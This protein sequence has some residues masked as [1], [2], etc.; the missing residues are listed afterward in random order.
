[1]H[2]EIQI[3]ELRAELRS[4]VDASGRRHI[5]AELEVL[6]A[7]LAVIAADQDDTIESAPPL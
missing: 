7:E 3:E 1:M 5:K 4:A 2:L 6:R